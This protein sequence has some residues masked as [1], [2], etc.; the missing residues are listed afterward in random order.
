MDSNKFSELAFVY[1][2]FPNV[3][4]CNLRITPENIYP[5]LKS[6]DMTSEISILNLDK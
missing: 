2:D 4:L 3:K 5:V 6:F 1:K